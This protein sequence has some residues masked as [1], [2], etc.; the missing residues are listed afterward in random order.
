LFQKLALAQ[1]PQKIFFHVRKFFSGNRLARDQNQ[2]HGTLELMLVQP[3]TFPQEPPR[4]AALDRRPDF[5][6]GDDSDATG[7]ARHQWQ[8]ICNETAA[9]HP[10][11]LQSSPREIAFFFQATGTGQKQPGR[12]RCGHAE[13]NRGQ[14]FAANAAA[15]GESGFPAL[16]GI[17][18]QKA[19]LP[20][21]A[22]F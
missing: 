7:R 8:K 6:A 17:T 13:L 1:G 15:I 22:D 4:A 10:L 19:M 14:A 9:D 11:T 16:A 20:S 21:A 12:R 18:I 5:F 3:I 2:I